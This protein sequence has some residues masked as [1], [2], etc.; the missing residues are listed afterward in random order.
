MHRVL[1]GRWVGL[2]GGGHEALGRVTHTHRLISASFCISV[3]WLL[4][5]MSDS[6]VYSTAPSSRALR[7][8]RR[9]RGWG[10]RQQGRT[11]G[12]ATNNDS[13]RRMKGCWEE[14]LP[15]TCVP[16]PPYQSNP[17]PPPTINFSTPH[18]H[19]HTGAHVTCPPPLH[20]RT[21]PSSPASRS[22]GQSLCGQ[23]P[24]APPGTS[25]PHAGPRSAHHGPGRTRQGIVEGG[26]GGG[27]GG[28]MRLGTVQGGGAP[29]VLW[30]TRVKPPGALVNASPAPGPPKRPPMQPLPCQHKGPPRGSMKGLEAAQCFRAHK[31]HTHTPHTPQ[32]RHAPPP[33]TVAAGSPRQ[34]PWPPPPWPG[35]QSTGRRL[36]PC[37]PPGPRRLH[38]AR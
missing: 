15:C 37:P 3:N 23:R 6:L 17:P 7:R 36:R 21:L 19:S 8:T 29:F 11:H 26:A 10:E 22:A 13:E 1:L 31:P 30:R 32:P 16:Q 12:P 28:F 33:E 5:M 18:P 38:W 34:T 20:K 2:G 35:S 4:V 27:Q 14:Q 24:A 9:H 25:P